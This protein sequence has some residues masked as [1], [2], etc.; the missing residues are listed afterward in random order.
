ME[1]T[2]MSISR[3]MDKW[4]WYVYTIE[5]YLAIKRKPFEP[6]PVRRMNLEPIRQSEVSQKEKNKYRILMHM[7]GIW[8]NG[9]DEAV[10]RAGIEIRMERT[11]LLLI[12]G[13][14][15]AFW[16]CGS[17]H[18][19]GEHVYPERAQEGRVWKANASLRC[20]YTPKGSKNRDWNRLCL[21]ASVHISIYNRKKV[22]APPVSIK[23][24]MD[25]QNGVFSCC[26]ILL[27][28]KKGWSS[29]TCSN[30]DEPWGFC[31]MWNTP[32]TQGQI[33]HEP[34]HMRSPEWSGSSDNE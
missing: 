6:V 22:E 4:L 34:T 25:Q 3:W 10:C 7:Y 15:S 2:Y 29:D 31:A 27:S 26:G 19:Q 14:L 21:Y 13:L 17:H 18:C 20:T 24:W 1:T 5:K 33:I 11:F 28:C 23:G 30:M 8:K 12:L 16:F 9:T 32:D